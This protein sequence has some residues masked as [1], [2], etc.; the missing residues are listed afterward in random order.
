M[1]K[2]VSHFFEPEHTFFLMRLSVTQQIIMCIPCQGVIIRV[3][4]SI[5]PGKSAKN[6]CHGF[7][8]GDPIMIRDDVV[9]NMNVRL[10]SKV[11]PD[12]LPEEKPALVIEYSSTAIEMSEKGSSPQSFVLK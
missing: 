6:E 2:H 1:P 12:A 10:I 3:F 5:P 4:R 8:P 11:N 7:F 9:K